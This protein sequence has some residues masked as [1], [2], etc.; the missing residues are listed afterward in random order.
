MTT[1]A[2]VTAV[3]NNFSWKWYVL[4]RI[5]WNCVGLLS[6][7]SRW[8][9]YDYCWLSHIVKGDTWRVPWFNK[10]FKFGFK[11]V[12]SFPTSSPSRGGDV[13]V[14]VF[15]HKPAELAH[16]FF[17][18]LVSVSVSMALSAVSHF[19]NSTDNSLLSHSVLPVLF[20]PYLFFQV[21]TSLWKSLSPDI[22]PCG[23]LG[24]KHQLP[25][26]TVPYLT[27]QVCVIV[28]RPSVRP[29]TVFKWGLSTLYDCNLAW[30]L[31]IHTRFNY[32][33]LKL[34]P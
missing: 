32:L 8:W 18:V 4:I 29:Q 26:L 5:I 7:P 19:I 23:W 1:T 2:T 33:F 28:V 27:V 9:V 20:L 31:P 24:L 15:W 16:S 12:L 10:T 22:I 11:T 14:Y 25:N 34:L 13:A 21:C 17:S 30:C 3:S 6:V